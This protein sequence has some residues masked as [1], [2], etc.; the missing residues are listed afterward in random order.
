MNSIIPIL[1]LHLVFGLAHADSRAEHSG[2]WYN[3]DQP[4]H[5]LSI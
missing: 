5:G 3:P 1:H 2:A 4:G